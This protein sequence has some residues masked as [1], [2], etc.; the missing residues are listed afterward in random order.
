MPNSRAK[1]LRVSEEDSEQGKVNLF[2]VFI[3]DRNN[4]ESYM[5]IKDAIMGW[6]YRTSG[7]C[8]K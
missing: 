2:P 8:I 4:E 5:R 3:E 7:R 6:T 1:G